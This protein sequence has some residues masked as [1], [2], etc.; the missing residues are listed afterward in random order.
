MTSDKLN[1]AVLVL[2]GATAGTSVQR[3]VWSRSQ[4][5]RDRE[6]SGFSETDFI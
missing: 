4:E 1:I 2:C 6:V 5:Q 3:S